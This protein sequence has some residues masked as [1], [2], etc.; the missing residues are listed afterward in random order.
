MIAV[1]RELQL[2]FALIASIKYARDEA[3]EGRAVIEALFQDATITKSRAKTAFRDAL[4]VTQRFGS[5]PQETRYKSNASTRRNKV[6]PD[7]R[8]RVINFYQRDDV[9]RQ[10]PGKRNYKVVSRGEAFQPT[11]DS[12]SSTIENYA[13]SSHPDSPYL[14]SSQSSSS[15]AD[16]S[17]LSSSQLEETNPSS[18]GSAGTDSVSSA[19]ST[20]THYILMKRVLG[21]YIYNIYDRFK[22]DFPQDNVSLAVFHRLHPKYVGLCSFLKMSQ[23]L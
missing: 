9:S 5:S 11:V 8:E 20:A 18:S 10:L 19:S 4:G 7:T 1:K 12:M 6:T 16:T 15:G 23:C 13:P 3:P 22:L 2:H 21:D 14:Y 17:S